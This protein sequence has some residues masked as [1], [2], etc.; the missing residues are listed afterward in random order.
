MSTTL[1][2]D[3]D[4]G[5]TESADALSAPS[6]AYSAPA[7][8]PEIRAKGSRNRAIIALVLIIAAL[9]FVVVRGLGDATLFFLNAD[10]AKT[11]AVGL[12]VKRFRLQGIV[13]DGTVKEAPNTVNFDVEFNGTTVH[14]RHAGAPPELFRPNIAVVLEG[15]FATKPTGDELPAF[16][17]DRILVKHDENYIQKNRAR[18]KDAVDAP[19]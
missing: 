18:L 15:N 16:L 13:V 9:G 3:S 10:E 6:T 7:G 12:G 2:T 17:S 5:L 8:L 14:V 19:A 1:P 4:T 11:Q